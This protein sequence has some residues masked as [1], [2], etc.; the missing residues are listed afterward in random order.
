[1]HFWS[2]EKYALLARRKICTFGPAKNMYF[3]AGEK[4]A[5]LGRRKICAFG[6]AKNMHFW[7]GEGSGQ[8]T[9]RHLMR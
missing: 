9:L 6:P 1:M 5:L 8:K 2:G 4:H 3:W 7:S